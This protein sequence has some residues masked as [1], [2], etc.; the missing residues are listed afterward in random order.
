MMREDTHRVCI[1]D[2]NESKNVIGV[3]TMSDIMGLLCVNH[4]P[5]IF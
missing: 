4:K 1:L 2:S 3:V 5:S